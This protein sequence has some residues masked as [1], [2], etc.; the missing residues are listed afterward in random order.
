MRE[1]VKW[2]A[3]Q[4]ESKLQENDHKGGWQDCD[5]QW[6]VKRLKEEVNELES[7]LK[8]FPISFNEYSENVIKESADVSNFS[9]MIADIVNKMC[10]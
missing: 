2:F 1:E 9:M 3:E 10:K 7:A 4:M 8:D 5:L 6:L